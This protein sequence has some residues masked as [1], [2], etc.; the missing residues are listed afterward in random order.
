MADVSEALRQRFVS[1]LGARWQ[2]IAGTPSPQESL[3][4]LHRLAGAAG[5]YGFEALGDAAR[6]AE[7]TCS[8]STDGWPDAA[9]LAEL[10]RCLVLAGLPADDTTP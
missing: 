1:G 6:R 10:R 8:V 4:A 9:A 5:S 3:Q 7:Q 2:A